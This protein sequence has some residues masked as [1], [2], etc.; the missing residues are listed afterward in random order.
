MPPAFPPPGW[1][2]LDADAD[3]VRV[4]VAESWPRLDTSLGAVVLRRYVLPLSGF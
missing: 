2:F 1:D 3:A 4:S